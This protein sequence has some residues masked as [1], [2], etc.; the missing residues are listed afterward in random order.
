[1]LDEIFGSLDE[2]RRANVL[3]LLRRLLDRFDQ[4]ILITHIDSVLSG[5]DRVINV[6]YDAPSGSSIIDG[7]V[8]EDASSEESA[9]L[10]GAVAE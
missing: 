2:V 3:E 1:V 6:R 4:V 9:E 10:A 7:G 5:H 8:L